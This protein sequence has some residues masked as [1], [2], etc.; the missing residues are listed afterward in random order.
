MASLRLESAEL[1]SYGGVV[2]VYAL[3]GWKAKEEIKSQ[4]DIGQS[5]LCVAH[6]MNMNMRINNVSATQLTG[7]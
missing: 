4:L 1:P 7:Q 6:V 3:K 5:L 2:Y